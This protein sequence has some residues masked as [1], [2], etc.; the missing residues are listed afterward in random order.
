[1]SRVKVCVVCISG[2]DSMVDLYSRACVMYLVTCQKS[3]RIF[4]KTQIPFH[5]FLQALDADKSGTVTLE[6]LRDGLQ[7][8]NSPV[9]QKEL[10]A[11]MASMDIDANGSIDYEEFLAATVNMSQLQVNNPMTPI[12][13]YNPSN[14]ILMSKDGPRLTALR[15]CSVYRLIEALGSAGHFQGH[16][17]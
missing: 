7:K 6:E 14:K 11:L 13:L 4:C 10:E 16:S 15:C 1:M 2:A 3:C 8:Q 17:L 5:R 12:T 9:T